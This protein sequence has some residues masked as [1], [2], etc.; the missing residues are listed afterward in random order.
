MRNR[1]VPGAILV[2]MAIVLSPLGATPPNQEPLRFDTEVIRIH[3]EPDSLRI[4]GHY[5]FIVP[6]P[7]PG[8]QSLFYPYPVDSLLGGARTVSLEW[9]RGDRP[10][11]TL[12]YHELPSGRG[13][14]W[15]VPLPDEG[16]V[17]V[18]TVYRQERLADYG[19]YIVT[20]TQDWANPLRHALFKIH[21]P[22]GARPLTFSHPFTRVST[23]GENCY[24]FVAN[25]FFPER[26]I[27]F[28]WQP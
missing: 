10:W 5:R 20:T 7:R 15:P 2:L 14:R 19:R 25:E 16:W 22:A 18:R 21:L 4:E 24:L 9:R 12:E 13:A 17:E 23:A 11:Q 8:F 27:I 3:V 6:E 26:D 28:T 1:I